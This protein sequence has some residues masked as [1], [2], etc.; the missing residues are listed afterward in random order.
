VDFVL[1]QKKIVT[2]DLE[3]QACNMVLGRLIEDNVSVK[4]LVTD[5]DRGIGL[6]GH[7]HKPLTNAFTC[8]RER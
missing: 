7:M 6:L 3:K 5:R 4:M 8:I 1:L 2:G